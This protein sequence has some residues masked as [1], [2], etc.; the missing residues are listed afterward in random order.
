MN[1]LFIFFVVA[2]VGTVALLLI[3][4]LQ[5]RNTIRVKTVMSKWDMFREQSVCLKHNV[6]K[7]RIIGYD[8]YITIDDCRFSFTSLNGL[9]QIND[10]EIHVFRNKTGFYTQQRFEEATVTVNIQY[11]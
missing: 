5:D 8:I 6:K 2:A 4:I 9:I 3:F 10:G 1:N 11:L 7:K